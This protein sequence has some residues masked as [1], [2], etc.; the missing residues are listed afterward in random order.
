V[1]VAAFPAGEVA[2]VGDYLGRYRP[3]FYASG[4]SLT[5][6]YMIE[7]QAGGLRVER[8]ELAAEALGD[9]AIPLAGTPTWVVTRDDDPDAGALY[10]STSRRDALD[11]FRR[12]VVGP[13]AP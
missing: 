10:S 2:D 3:R 13:V 5:Y 11:S 9:D 7:V 1:S 4:Y 6:S 12:L 8:R